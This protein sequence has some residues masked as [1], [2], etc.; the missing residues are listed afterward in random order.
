MSIFRIYRFAVIAMVAALSSLAGLCAPLGDTSAAAN[1]KTPAPLITQKIDPSQLVEL[2]GNVYPAATA[3]ADIGAAAASLALDRMVLVLKRSKSQQ[4]A[5]DKFVAQQHNAKSES[6]HRWLTPQQYGERFGLAQSDI[7]AIVDWLQSNGFS[8]DSTSPSRMAITFSGTNAQLNAAFH[9]AVHSYRVNGAVR[10]ANSSNPKIPAALANAVAGI[11]KLNDFP[12]MPMHS[13]AIVARHE[14]GTGKWKPLSG[15]SLPLNPNFRLDT[16]DGYTLDVVGPQ[17]FAKIYNLQAT[18]DKGIDGTGQ[19]IAIV[20]PS[21][22]NPADVDAFRSAFGLPAAKLDLIYVGPNPGKQSS[23]EGETDLDVQ[24]SGAVAKNAT[25]HVV[26]AGD[27]YTTAGVDLSA[28]YIIDHVVAPVM[29]ESY[30]ECEVGLGT[31]GNAFYNNLWEQAAAEGI[32]AMVSSGDAGSAACDQ[33]QF[34]AQFGMA[35]NGIGS[36]PYN[37]SVGGT[38]LDGTFFNEDAYWNS[39]NGT[40]LSS[41]KSYVPES[42]WNN[43]CGN[44]LLLDAYHLLGYEL[45]DGEALCNDPVLQTYTVTTGGGS[46]GPSMCTTSEGGYLDSCRDGY[47]KPAWQSGIPGIPNDGHRD[48]PDVSLFSGS[49]LWGSSLPFCESDATPNGSCDY[50]DPDTASMLLAG[51]TS[52]ASPAVAGIMALVNQ[53]AGTPQGNAN[54]I[55]YKLAARQYNNT[56]LGTACDSAGMGDAQECIFH[57]VTRGGIAVPCYAGSLDC[58]VLRSSDSFGLLPGWSANAGYDMATGLGSL[59]ITRMLAA[60]DSASADATATT[61]TLG[62][63]TLT[64]GSAL[65]GTVAVQAAGSGSGT[66]T[67]DTSLL[68][69]TASLAGGPFTLHDGKADVSYSRLPVGT[70]SVTAHYAGDGVFGASDSDTASVTVSKANSTLSITPSATDVSAS[71]TLSLVVTLHTQSEATSPTGAIM[72]RSQEANAAVGSVALSPAV[73]ADGNSIAI[74]TLSMPARALAA[75][76]NTL[77][78]SYAGDGNYKS[79]NAGSVTV[80]YT[81]PFQL[82]V[83]S[84]PGATDAV[85]SGVAVHAS[86]KVDANGASL[87]V[88]TAL[89]CSSQ[90]PGVTCSFTPAS[91]AAGSLGGTSEVSI[92][93]SASTQASTA[94]PAKW[95][96]H[97]GLFSGALRVGTM[98]GFAFL[99][100][101]RVRRRSKRWMSLLLVALLPVAF[102]I[103]CGGSHHA[104][105]SQ[106]T[107]SSSTQFATMNSA[108]ALTASINWSETAHAGSGSVV[109]YDGSVKIGEGSVSGGKATFSTT[110]LSRG[111]HSLMAIY[112]GDNRFAGSS[113]SILTVVVVKP[114]TVTLTAADSLGDVSSTNITMNLK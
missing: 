110:T 101:P 106:I 6:Y 66:P 33:N 49:G 104:E 67:G 26:I 59:N 37:V 88:D 77:T 18:W 57:D 32:T 34:A 103:G 5:L 19:H 97:D 105:S 13:R 54:Y 83:I 94:R 68:A 62:T 47:A 65:T 78:A 40:G 86:V 51:G 113:S 79:S 70:H 63:T 91:F 8:V 72:V 56:Q 89:S 25:V 58:T 42:P 112:T 9:T 81:A 50:S 17:D 31:A 41:A 75:G 15:Q 38:D 95:I 96:P 39:S 93:S 84:G 24:W 85:A 46:G 76:V 108:V 90:E 80:M 10:Y 92:Q 52:F 23:T 64:Y 11:A 16:S 99:F 12:R 114:V 44:P 2:K 30:G 45:A 7:A 69:A 98:A 29:S 60:W 87:P 20:S 111:E 35:V 22:I 36:T 71:Q 3:N 27:T 14:S 102:F 55:F 61:L 74:A 82:S 53:Q 100:L 109:F 1:S 4:D 28:M 73:D 107:L 48:L 43:S 21:D